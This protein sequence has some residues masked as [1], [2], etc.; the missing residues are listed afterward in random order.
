MPNNRRPNKS[1]SFTICH[2]KINFFYVSRET[3]DNEGEEEH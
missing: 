1:K 2:K 3:N